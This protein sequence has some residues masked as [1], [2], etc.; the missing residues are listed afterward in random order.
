M[1]LLPFPRQVHQPQTS[2]LTTAAEAANVPLLPLAHHHLGSLPDACASSRLEPPKPAPVRLSYLSSPHCVCMSPTV[3][4]SE[5]SAR[6]DRAF[7]PHWNLC[8]FYAN[9]LS[10]TPYQHFLPCRS[11]WSI[12]EG[13]TAPC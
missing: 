9:F 13:S 7:L 6:L 4:H 10:Y 2:S 11:L 3:Q 1:V 5:L 8:T 12:C